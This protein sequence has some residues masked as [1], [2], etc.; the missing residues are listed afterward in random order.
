[1]AVSAGAGQPHPTTPGAAGQAGQ[2]PMQQ[3]P[4]RYRDKGTQDGH[5]L[6]VGT[7]THLRPGRLTETLTAAVEDGGPSPG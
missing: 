1:M 5:I 2:P 7:W 3:S 6:T 4:W